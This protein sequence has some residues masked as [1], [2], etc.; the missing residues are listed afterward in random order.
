[1]SVIVKDEEDNITLFCKGAESALI[2]K[3]IA[4]PTEE[5]LRH[6]SEFAMVGVRPRR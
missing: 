5:T 1:M 6:V 2:P 4:G 3:V